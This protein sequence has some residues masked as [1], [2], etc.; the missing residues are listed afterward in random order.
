MASHGLVGSMSRRGNPYDNAMMESF[1]KTLKVEAVYPM[2]FETIEDVAEHLPRFDSRA[3]MEVP[4]QLAGLG[5]VG[6]AAR[7]AGRHTGRLPPGVSAD[8]RFSGQMRRETNI[9]MARP[10]IIPAKRSIPGQILS[11]GPQ[12]WTN[13]IIRT[14]PAWVPI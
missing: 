12:P 3:R 6:G 10:P 2:A 11:G 13:V 1:M 8:A 5:V 14:S 4:Q 9:S 7:A